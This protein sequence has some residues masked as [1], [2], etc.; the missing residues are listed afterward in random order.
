VLAFAGWPLSSCFWDLAAA[1]GYSILV[2]GDVPSV[3][4]GG[5]D[6]PLCHITPP[7]VHWR[8]CIPREQV[9]GRRIPD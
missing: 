3:L 9:Q 6:N 2:G 4:N 8:D 5:L 1:F 7:R